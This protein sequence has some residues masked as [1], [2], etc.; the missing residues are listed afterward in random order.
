MSELQIALFFWIAIVLGAPSSA[1]LL[2]IITNYFD[3]LNIRARRLLKENFPE[4]K[5]RLLITNSSLDEALFEAANKLGIP[6]TDDVWPR[7]YVT[8]LYVE[9]IEKYLSRTRKENISGDTQE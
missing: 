3:A 2:L 8:R 6:P 1:Y 5:G 7:R 4:M 9:R